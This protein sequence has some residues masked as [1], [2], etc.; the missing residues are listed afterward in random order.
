MWPWENRH[1]IPGGCRVL[2]RRFE[3]AE[4]ALYCDIS[5]LDTELLTDSGGSHYR[6]PICLSRWCEDWGSQTVRPL[7]SCLTCTISTRFLSLSKMMFN[8]LEISLASAVPASLRNIPDKY[9]I[10]ICLWTNCFY[11][12]LEN[13]RRSS[14]LPRLRW[15][16]CKSLLCIH[17][18]HNP[19]RE[20][21]FFGLLSRLAWG[22]WWPRT[23]SY[24]HSRDG[25]YSPQVSSSLTAATVNGGLRTSP[26][27]SSV[28]S[29]AMSTTSSEK[30]P[31]HPCS[32]TPSVG[33]I[34]TWLMELEPEKDRWRRVAREWYAKVVTEFPGRG[35]LHHHLGLLSHWGRRWGAMCGLP[36]CQEVSQLVLKPW[37]LSSSSFDLSVWLL[38]IRSRRLGSPCSYY[39][40]QWHRHDARVLTLARRNFLFSFTACSL[41]ISSWM[42]S[43]WPWCVSLNVSASKSQKH[44]NGQWWWWLTLAPFSST[45]D[46]KLSCVTCWNPRHAIVQSPDIYISLYTSVSYSMCCWSPYM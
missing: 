45:A 2:V 40:P 25:S 12:L 44:E 24:C 16:T 29:G 6:W 19:S 34:A 3:P 13:L 26:H 15:N 38:H 1:E 39:G 23:I 22:S 36:L 21:H 30:H 27:G 31:A 46:H 14:S 18:L 11:R 32:P 37:T 43:P 7:F 9:N 17:F 10:I 42:I 33:I 20:K 8:L 5:H 41:Q 35:K 28:S 4:E